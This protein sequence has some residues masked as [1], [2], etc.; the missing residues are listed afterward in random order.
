MKKKKSVQ[1]P[2]FI[3]LKEGWVEGAE[4]TAV[5]VS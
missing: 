2:P 1:P 5:V 4:L 3:T